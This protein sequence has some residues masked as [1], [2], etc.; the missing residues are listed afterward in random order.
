MNRSEAE[1][2]AC[3]RTFKVDS[4]C[5]LKV[6]SLVEKS[7]GTCVSQLP[8]PTDFF[9]HVFPSFAFDN[10]GN[11]LLTDIKIFRLFCLSV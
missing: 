7:G 8:R 3:P 4:P 9:L 2:Q 5:P 10:I 1:H 6:E 11:C